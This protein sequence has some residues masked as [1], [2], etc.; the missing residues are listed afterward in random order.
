M[1][2]WARRLAGAAVAVSVTAG[3]GGLSQ[4]PFTH[5]PGDGGLI[6]LSWRVAGRRVEECRTLS[7]E[8]LERRP[9]H[10]RQQE[11][12][13]GRVLPYRLRVNIDGQERADELLHAPGAHEDRPIYVLDEFS[14]E[15][16]AHRVRI[17]FEEE[18]RRPRTGEA[19]EEPR[20]GEAPVAGAS[21]PP[22][23]VMD[24]VL[25]VG[26]RQVHLVTYDA[27]RRL[28]VVAGRSPE[29]SS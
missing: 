20:R 15:R 19:P 4:V 25:E 24:T 21:A 8:E 3:V 7:T 5:E 16:G 23:L 28:L 22:S 2:V 17:S 11:V 18:P 29:P 6:R 12:C 27:E 26:P 1:S 13:E 9:Q 14:V 10:M